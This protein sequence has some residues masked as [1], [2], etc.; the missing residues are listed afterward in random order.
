MKVLFSLLSVLVVFA[1]FSN[2][3]FAQQNPP[4]PPPQPT[5]S[6]EITTVNGIYVDMPY[7]TGGPANHVYHA[8]LWKYG[9]ANPPLRK[10][11]V[12]YRVPIIR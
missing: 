8:R 1:G 2:A 7:E 6:I 5:Y 11:L 4:P 10:S 9:N 3:A 12:Q